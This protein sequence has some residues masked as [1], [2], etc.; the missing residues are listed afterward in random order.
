MPKILAFAGS[1]RTDSYNKR[2][3]AVAAEAA[4]AAGAEVEVIDLRDFPM[5][6]LDEDEER[7]NGKP[8]AA[9]ALKAKMAASDG[10]LISSPEYNGGIT[11]V[12]K[13]AI[14]WV[15]RPDEGDAPRSMPAFQGKTVVLMSASPGGLGGLRAL[16]H[17][18]DILSGVGC[19]VLP[20][21]VA[22]SAA[23]KEFDEAGVMNAEGFRP[24]IEAL[25]T[26]L[27]EYLARQG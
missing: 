18:R 7:A 11:G 19:I 25:G 14:D 9:L 24:R 2:V 4:R 16:F 1:T 26:T 10:F 8:A 3:V 6:L 27:A 5:P 22:V 15:S 21:Q 20:Q 12:L 23:Y 17:V 13:N